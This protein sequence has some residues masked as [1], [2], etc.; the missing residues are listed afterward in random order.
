MYY[1]CIVRVSLRLTAFRSQNARSRIRKK[2]PLLYLSACALERVN[3]FFPNIGIFRLE[4]PVEAT[5]KRPLSV[6]SHNP[7]SK[8]LHSALCTL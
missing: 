7:D 8:G 1:G 5:L 4:R 3:D 6:G 2:G